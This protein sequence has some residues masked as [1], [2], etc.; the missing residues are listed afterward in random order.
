MNLLEL[1]GAEPPRSSVYL[2]L[3]KDEFLVD[4]ALDH[5]RAHT[6][7]PG[8]AEFNHRV[9]RCSKTM[10]SGVVLDALAEL[11]M[12]ASVRLLELRGADELAPP[13]A[14]AAVAGLEQSA[15]DP[16]VVTVLTAASLPKK[17]SLLS[18]AAR[19]GV[20]VQA[21]VSE[22]DRPAWLRSRLKL[23]KARFEND[24]QQEL[25]TRVGDELRLLE[26]HVTRLALYAGAEPVT[27]SM[28]REMVPFSA[29][30]QIWRLTAAIGQ[31]SLK[32]SIEVLDRLMADDDSPIGLLSYLNSYCNSMAQVAHLSHSQAALKAAF[33][34]KKEF[35]LKKQVQEAATWTSRDLS[36]AFESLLR[37]DLRLKTG[38]DGRMVMQLLLMQLCSRQG[39]QRRRG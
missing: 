28:V 22:S 38:S 36:T 25:L 9:L 32:E 12:L 11:P 37:A 17:E 30:V 31:G 33:P 23:H 3:G 18:A 13:V 8:L 2:V 35:Q 21:E 24:A 29:S 39:L 26:S 1:L 10:K 19:L 4:L 6:L 5:L 14:Q 27:R 34:A 15:R 7:E 20:T 16:G